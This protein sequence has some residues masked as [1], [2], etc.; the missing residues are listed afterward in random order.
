MTIC[1]IHWEVPCSSNAI[2]LSI[3]PNQLLPQLLPHLISW[4]DSKPSL[5]FLPPA[6]SPVYLYAVLRDTVF[7][8]WIDLWV[9]IVGFIFFWSAVSVSVNIIQVYLIWKSE[10]LIVSTVEARKEGVL[11]LL[12]LL[13]LIDLET[14]WN[15]QLFVMWISKEPYICASESLSQITR[16]YI[17][18]SLDLLKAI[19]WNIF[20]T[21]V[22]IQVY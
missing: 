14:I 5:A 15:L 3:H 22:C 2:T 4:L 11:R 6:L 16:L 12:S 20:G 13:I 21:P 1:I 8:K 10:Q 7:Q 19:V 17:C 18:H 9:C